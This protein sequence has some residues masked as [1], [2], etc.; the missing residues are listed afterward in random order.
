M[1]ELNIPPIAATDVGSVELARVWAAKGAQHVTIRVGHWTDPAAW[2]IFLVDLARHVARAYEQSDGKI[3]AQILS[4]IK[5]G[6]DAEWESPTD[7][8]TGRT[9]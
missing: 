5:A 4:R 7:N 6:F 8:P 2:G 1:Q 9:T 3:Q